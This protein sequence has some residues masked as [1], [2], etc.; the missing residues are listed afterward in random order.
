MPT[1]GHPQSG[2]T[3][4]GRRLARAVAAKNAEY[5]AGSDREAHVIDATVAP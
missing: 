2:K 3:L 1:V 5:L 4:D